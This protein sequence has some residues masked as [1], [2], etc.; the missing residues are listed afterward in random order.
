MKINT[1]IQS[2][3]TIQNKLK[4]H[5][6]NRINERMEKHINNIKNK[7]RIKLNTSNTLKRENNN[8][9]MK[10]VPENQ[11]EITADSNSIQYS[12]Q[13]YSRKIPIKQ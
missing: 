9:L 12:T 6:T 10:H 2:Q 13:Q 1:Q 5:I 8:K 11:I 7:N 4:E 3:Y